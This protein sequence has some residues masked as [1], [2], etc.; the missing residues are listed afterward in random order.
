MSN[1]LSG[2]SRPRRFEAAARPA[3][4]LA[5][6]ACLAVGAAF[7]PPH[8]AAAPSATER[9][10]DLFVHVPTSA[11]GGD[12]LPISVQALGFP[13]AT[14]VAPVAG[15]AIE[16]TWDPESLL[17]PTK[18]YTAPPLA[19]LTVQATADADGRAT[20][21]LP[22]P[23]GRTKAITLLVSVKTADRERVREVVI[24]RTPSERLD[25]FVSD[26][27][28]VPGS[29]V[30]AWSL[31]ASPDRSKPVTGAPIEY[32]LTQGGMVR[33]KKTATTDGAG[34]TM[35]RVPIPRDD[36]PG[37]EWVLTA[38]PV[39]RPEGLDDLA[40]TVNLAAREETPG[41]P[42]LWSTFDEG[43]VVAGGKARYRIR[44]RDAS[45]EGVAGHEIWVW[46][47]P[48]GTAAPKDEEPFRKVAARLVTDGAGEVVADVAAPSTI[49]LRGTEV[50]LEA[51]TLI[52]GLPRTT[53]S[54]IEVGQRRG[55]AFLTPEAGEIVPG[56]EQKLVL[57]L[58]GD[59][60]KPIVGTFTAKGDGLDATFTTNDQGEAEIPWKAP[61]GIG[62][63]RST[64]PCPGQ[65]AAQ[66]TLRAKEA[67]V[68]AKL[69]FG[70]ALTDPGGMPLCVPVRRDATALVRPSKLVV[71]EGE[72]LSFAILGGDKRPASVF[73]TQASGAQSAALWTADAGKAQTIGVPAGASGTL[74]LHAALPRPHG[75]TEIASAA[76]L[77][78]PS[79]LPKVTAS[80][81]G[82]RAAPGGKVTVTAELADENGKPMVGSIAAV[83]IDKLGGGSFGPLSSI[84]T[85][86]EL[87]ED[88]GASEER[89]EL[90]LLGGPEMDPLRR[91]HLRPAA[92][93]GPISDPAANAKQD[94]NDTFAA[95]V[96]SLEGA[97]FEAAQAKE[98]LP[99]VRRKENGK[100]VFNPEL[101]TLVTDAMTEQPTTPGGEPVSLGDLMAVDGQITF[102]NVAKRVTR[103][104]LFTVLDQVR[105]SRGGFDPDEPLFADPN[106][107]LR[108]LVREGTVG[109]PALLD[110][111]GGQISFHKSDGEYV[112]FISF[113]RGWE[114]RSPGPDGKMGS[115]D[116]VKSPFERVLKAGTP[117]AL[118]MGEQNILDAR[119][120]MLVADVTVEAWRRT[121]EEHTGTA[122]GDSFGAG[123]LALGGTGMGGG[124]SGHGMG[125]GGI[126]GRGTSSVPK[127][128]A[129][130]VA[131]IRTDAA[132]RVTF[133]IPLGDLET[134][135]RVAV[136]G[137]PDGGRPAMNAIDVPVTIP[138]SAKVLA[139][140][141]WTDEDS[142]EIVVQ[143]RNRSDADAAVALEMSATGTL[144]LDPAHAKKTVQ[145]GKRGAALVRV[146][147][148]A[149]GWGGGALEVRT[150]APGLP[151]D[152]LTHTLEV[153]PKGELLR[154]AR[155]AW[156][157][158][159]QDLGPALDR[160]PFIPIGAG[161]LVLDRGDK[162]V[163]E[164]ALESLAP[165]QTG[166]LE[167]L[168]NIAATAADLRG[169]FVSLEGD[170]SKLAVRAKEV[171]R[172]ASGKLSSL[173]APQHAMAFSWLG[174]TALTGFVESAD[175]IAKL[176]DCP[177]E[178]SVM[179]NSALASA[180]DA[181]PPPTGGA[182]R[183]CWTT[184]A[185]SATNALVDGSSV[186]ELARGVL[187]VARR[188]HRSGEL[189]TLREK[190]EK[191]VALDDEG[192][193]SVDAGAKRAD[194]ALAY[195]A[196]LAASDPT[197]DRARRMLL[198]KWLLVQRDAKGSFGSAAATRGAVQAIIREASH[199]R[200]D[201][202]PMK[203]RVD[204][205]DAGEQEVSI[206]SNEQKRLT[207]PLKATKVVVLPAGESGVSARLERTFLRPYSVAPQ[208]GDSPLNL[209][210]EWPRAP[211]CSAELQKQGLCATDL[212][213]GRVG[214]LRLK[215]SLAAVRRAE[216]VDVRIPLPPG[217][218][219]AD[220]VA[221]VRQLQGAL[222]VRA[223]VV[224]EHTLTIPLRFT[225]AG[226]FTAREATGKL[227]SEEGDLAIARARPVS[228][229]P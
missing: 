92:P 169:H 141:S 40:R 174:R 196:L 138:L 178:P 206:G 155:A 176:P 23:K 97:V 93:L 99:D 39:G 59:D 186:G 139:G 209:D 137:L 81:T 71:R 36:E 1:E 198:V 3:W 70:G 114:L 54:T 69:T 108:K 182:V 193:I 135:W 211:E 44:V 82:G 110:P 227:R 76:V 62:A 194:R 185:A 111:W 189:A 12:V 9:G 132:G 197:K 221:G 134:T 67:S 51:R 5:V 113:K 205:G 100:Y 79:R 84:D 157:T 94:M 56:L 47:G 187:A 64:G 217:V 127:G 27:R 213:Q 6:A 119:Y 133:E 214:N 204:F 190:L 10:L 171:G 85:R 35:M 216:T 68:G 220:T 154:I 101:M 222:Y 103:L 191:R 144:V 136:V 148:R 146:P 165:E 32:V 192:N 199:L 43:R 78:L 86:S 175:S 183:D 223:D 201:A 66:V 158:K 151:E 8:A 95:V 57:G 208:T 228:I 31:W 80:V 87:C 149:K 159:E 153:R 166:S 225:L 124:G 142:G 11:A 160:K 48:T 129:H 34:A 219:L 63:A 168:A 26:P 145:V 49:P 202:S 188:P 16:V 181:E 107:F 61:K 128:V 164:A 179:S 123:G 98:T 229:K 180:L 60:D 30:V 162:A 22:V 106:V 156:V 89:C 131:P 143:V 4:S 53:K 218:T 13:T 91:G 172:A 33:F 75:K 52:E 226:E 147:V 73:L 125:M 112:P 25:L 41:K 15:A 152:T 77:V 42:T 102:D 28:V 105:L 7:L 126:G 120:E 20:L 88:V 46:T 55:Y 177:S 65:V 29:E 19:P 210:L 90:A 37:A 58:W 104:K 109:E 195:A 14:T 203:V 121:F 212:K 117:Y 18:K 72:A 173:V 200:G 45:G 21:L 83:V 17:D 161:E 74:T 140:A 118:A 207:I 115:G 96:K 184:F 116:D 215:M 224:S 24:Q 50:H 150:R 170:G 163:L 167:E 2:A 38:R 122:L 130:V